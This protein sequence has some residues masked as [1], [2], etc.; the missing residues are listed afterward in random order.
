MTEKIEIA[1]FGGSLRIGSYNKLLLEL[2]KKNMPDNTF[3]NI[4][5]ISGI[6][7]FNEERIKDSPQKIEEMREA[8]MRSR[9][10]LVV[11][12]E[13][14]YSVPGFL[15]NVVDWLS[16]PPEKNPFRNK[17]IA[18]MSVS[19]GM[20]GGSRA[21]YHLRQIFQFLD[22]D[23]IRKPE[24]FVSFGGQAFDQDGNLKNPLS[25]KFV[26]ELLNILVSRGLEGAGHKQ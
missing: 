22:A 25:M 21:Q 26:T 4:L 18:L 16:V 3:L 5:D 8:I 7:N 11:S 14:N 20:L 12:P 24:V 2:C 19:G 9:G 13:Y 23:V 17:P 1:G 10:V 15:K 6:E